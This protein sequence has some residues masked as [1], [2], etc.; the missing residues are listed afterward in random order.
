MWEPPPNTKKRRVSLVN[1]GTFCDASVCDV[2]SVCKSCFACFLFMYCGFLE[3]N[4]I[5]CILAS[6][7]RFLPWPG[8]DTEYKVSSIQ[9][10]MQVTS[11][12][13]FSYEELHWIDCLTLPHH[14]FVSLFPCLIWTCDLLR[15]IYIAAATARCHIFFYFRTI[16]AT[17]TYSTRHLT[18]VMA[19][20]WGL[21]SM[22]QILMEDGQQDLQWVIAVVFIKW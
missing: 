9:H 12:C 21:A 14:R 20:M 16:F 1:L 19:I 10:V 15:S 5:L 11:S 2:V 8:I 7:F 4:F 3:T 17:W 22:D 6:S 13:H 18:A